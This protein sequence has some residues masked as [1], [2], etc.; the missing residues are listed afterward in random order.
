L[1]R[2]RVV[3]STQDG[4]RIAEE[5]LRRRGTGDL[6]GTRQSG[7]PELR[8]AD[9]ATYVGLVE[10]A[11]KEAEAVLAADPDL[12]RPEHAELRR[13]VKERFEEARPVAEEAG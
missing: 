6:Q 2:L 12:V 11:R 4:F 1:G 13:A 8:F 10:R 7:A 3:A 9:L 5:D